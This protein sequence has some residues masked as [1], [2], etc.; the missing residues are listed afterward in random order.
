MALEPAIGTTKCC[1]EA[2]GMGGPSCK[3]EED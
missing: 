2:G 1:V 3:G